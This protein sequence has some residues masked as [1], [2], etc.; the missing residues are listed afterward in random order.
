MNMFLALLTIIIMAIS[1]AYLGVSFEDK[2][3]ELKE[4]D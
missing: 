3:R 2:V 1:I 4:K